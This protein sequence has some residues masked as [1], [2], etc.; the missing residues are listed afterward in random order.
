VRQL[1]ELY[2]MELLGAVHIH[3][4]D[5]RVLLFARFC[6]IQSRWEAL[7]PRAGEPA[8]AELRPAL[9]VCAC[10]LGWR[11][12]ARRLDGHFVDF[13]LVLLAEL[14]NTIPRQVLTLASSEDDTMAVLLASVRALFCLDVSDPRD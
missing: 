14:R 7:A 8:G 12:I 13:F 10:R 11:S 6:G 3:M 5:S 9:H 4:A 1:A 2:L